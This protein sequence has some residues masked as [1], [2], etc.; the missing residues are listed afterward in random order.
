MSQLEM[1]FLESCDTVLS[2]V[3]SCVL[4]SAAAPERASAVATGVIFTTI[5]IFLQN[6]FFY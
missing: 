1:F 5:S 6:V 2:N 3:Y 4:S